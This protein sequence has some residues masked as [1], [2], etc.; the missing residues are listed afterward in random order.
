MYLH[1]CYTTSVKCYK[2]QMTIYH[3]I[4]KVSCHKCHDNRH[5]MCQVKLCD[6]HKIGSNLKSLQVTMDSYRHLCQCRMI[7]GKQKTR[8]SLPRVNHQTVRCSAAQC[9]SPSWAGKSGS[10]RVGTVRGGDRSGRAESGFCVYTPA[11]PH[12][13]TS[14]SFAPAVRAELPFH[15][16]LL[17]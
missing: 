15:Y 8:P 12:S 6:N 10:Q 1:F 13:K 16:L 5:D 9:Q 17:L 11:I 2:S 14:K 3:D 4:Q 7:G